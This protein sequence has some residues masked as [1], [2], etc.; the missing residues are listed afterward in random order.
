MGWKLWN[1]HE[2][3]IDDDERILEQEML[4]FFTTFSTC[5]SNKTCKKNLPSYFLSSFCSLPVNCG[6]L[7]CKAI[8]YSHHVL[9]FGSNK[10]SK[11]FILRVK[12]M[13]LFLSQKKVLMEKI[14]R[15]GELCSIVMGDNELCLKAKGDKT[16]TGELYLGFSQKLLNKMVIEYF[17]DILSKNVIW[18]RY[19]L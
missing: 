17:F 6:I 10:S 13:S 5:F 19:H 2:F 8:C 15:N 3:K 7:R 9:S 16:W 1:H 4:K 11:I 14:G 12:P 18:T